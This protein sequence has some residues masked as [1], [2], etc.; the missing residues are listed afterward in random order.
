VPIA[1][2]EK[3][4]VTIPYIIVGLTAAAFTGFGA[5]YTFW[6]ETMAQLTDIQ[7]RTATARIDF[8][9]TYGGFELGFAAFLLLSLRRR[10][11]LESGLWA[12][13][14]SLGG[15]AAVRL[16]SLALSSSPARPVIYWALAL[17]LGGVLL[18]L[19]GLWT[20]RQWVSSVHEQ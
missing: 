9:A 8:A 5:A 19:W 15:F 16:I 11:W 3:L 2:W 14:L 12:G 10:A 7:L 13:V 20:M 17:E 6:P 1:A 4:V 18:N